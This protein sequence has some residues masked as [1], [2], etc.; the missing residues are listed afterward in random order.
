MLRSL[1]LNLVEQWWVHEVEPAGGPAE[2]GQVPGQVPGQGFAG[3][4]ANAPGVYDP[5]GQCSI[6]TTPRTMRT[7]PCWNC[8]P[9][10]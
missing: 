7:W 2:P 4:L 5:A 9:R 6:S 3:S 10:P 1:S 8:E